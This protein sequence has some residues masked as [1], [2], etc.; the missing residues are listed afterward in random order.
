MRKKIS[1]ANL[2]ARL[3]ILVLLAVI[4]SLILFLRTGLEQRDH[5]AEDSQSYALFLAR[6]A[7]SEQEQLIDEARQ[8]LAT[9]ALLPQIQDSNPETCN[10]LLARLIQDNQRYTSLGLVDL[11]GSIICSSINFT[12]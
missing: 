2:R 11:D 1:F 12:L 3:F 10:D 6:Q 4:P 7:A 5:A 8:F 9:L